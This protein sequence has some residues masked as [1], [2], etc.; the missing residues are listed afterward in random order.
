VQV[1]LL[2]LNVGRQQQ[3]EQAEKAGNPD[4]VFT[5]GL[6]VREMDCRSS[7]AEGSPAVLVQ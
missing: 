3:E 7:R 2:R 5:V 6:I 1:R 4:H